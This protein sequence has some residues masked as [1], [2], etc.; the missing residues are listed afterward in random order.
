MGLGRDFQPGMQGIIPLFPQ[1]ISEPVSIMAAVVQEPFR[2]GQADQKSGCTCVVA[3]RACS[4]NRADRVTAG[5]PLGVHAAHGLADQTALLVF[6]PALFQ[7]Q[8][9]D[10]ALRP[11]AGRVDHHRLRDCLVAGLA[12]LYEDSPPDL[13]SP[14][15]SGAGSGSSRSRAVGQRTWRT[16][17]GRRPETRDSLARH[18]GGSAGGLSRQPGW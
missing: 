18:C 5:V 6:G 14:Q 9:G 12:H 4:H 3:D 7:P 17:D 8:A 1:H 13:S 15:G 16:A 2:L 10:R 11:R